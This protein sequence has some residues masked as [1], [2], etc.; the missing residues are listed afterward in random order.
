[1]FLPERSR[2]LFSSTVYNIE[3]RNEKDKVAL[4]EARNLRLKRQQLNMYQ[5]IGM[6]LPGLNEEQSICAPGRDFSLNF[7]GVDLKSD[8]I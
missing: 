2:I 6:D 4:L 3:K 8:S 5:F 1:M 7:T